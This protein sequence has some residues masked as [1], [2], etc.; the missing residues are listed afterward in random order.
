ML[1]EEEIR[2]TLHAQRIVPVDVANPHGPLGLEQLAGALAQIRG[3]EL[4]Q[5]VRRPIALN[6][7]T[8]EKLDR[9]AEAARANT[10]SCKASDLAAAVIDQ[11]V[12]AQQ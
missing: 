2:R 1:T 3:E 9:M 11:F 6:V 5:R 10:P 4:P 7:E 12:A 8:W